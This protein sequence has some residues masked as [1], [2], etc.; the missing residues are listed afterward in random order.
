MVCYIVLCGVVRCCVVL[1]CGCA[2]CCHRQVCVAIAIAAV[3]CAVQGETD[4]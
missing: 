2:S 4:F 1:L 3:S